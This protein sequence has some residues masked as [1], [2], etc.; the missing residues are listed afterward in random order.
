MRYKTMDREETTID[1]VY[2]RI[3]EGTYYDDHDYASGPGL[4]A[5]REAVRREEVD[6]EFMRVADW[7]LAG[8]IGRVVVVWLAIMGAAH[9]IARIIAA[10]AGYE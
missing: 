5:L 7:T 2:R 6:R 3:L 9:L 1:E 10:V 8:V 4:R